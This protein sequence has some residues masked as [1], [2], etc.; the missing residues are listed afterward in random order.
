MTEIINK[1]N[2]TKWLA[3]SFPYIANLLSDTIIWISETVFSFPLTPEHTTTIFILCNSFA[4]LFGIQIITNYTHVDN[5][6]NYSP[7]K[8]GFR[9][10][11]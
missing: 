1:Q 9:N 6:E 10:L 3:F 11:K 8:K 4:I 7:A 2:F 5:C